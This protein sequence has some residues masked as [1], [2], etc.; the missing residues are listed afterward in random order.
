MRYGEND[1]NRAEVTRLAAQAVALPFG[2]FGLFWVYIGLES[3]LRGILERDLGLL[4][5][6]AMF[7]AIGGILVAIAWQ[8]VRHFGARSIRDLTGLLAFAVYICISSLLSP[9]WGVPT[10]PGP[11]FRL[12]VAVLLP[13]FSALFFYRVLSRELI[14]MTGTAKLKQ[15][16]SPADR[17]PHAHPQAK[18][19]GGSLLPPE[20][21]KDE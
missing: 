1:V 10:D 11:Q 15:N 14:A 13:V 6:A 4:S 21:L 20:A 19:A 18:I 3:V 9:L 2:L 7:L 17:G 8:N 12:L 5:M 16:G